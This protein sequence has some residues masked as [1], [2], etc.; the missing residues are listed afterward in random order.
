MGQAEHRHTKEQLQIISEFKDA[1]GIEADEI[2]FY[3]DAPEPD[4][5]FEALSLLSLKLGEG[6]R[7]VS[8]GQLRVDS[9]MASCDCTVILDDG[10]TRTFFGCCIIGEKTLDGTLVEDARKA[11]D[12]ASARALRKGL[13]GVGFDPLKA[14][15]ARQRGE[16]VT[17]E[18]EVSQRVK[19]RRA[20]HA[21]RD[22]LGLDDRTYRDYLALATKGKRTTLDM[23]EEDMG[24]AAVFFR[25]IRAARD[26]RS[27]NA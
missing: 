11:L 6:I 16:A 18:E 8:V 1:Y 9:L 21:L 3:G 26:Y 12:F 4:F 5:T 15:R 7:D 14:H 2:F 25:G 19:D 24:R 20:I 22:E 10:R 27:K 13:R 23:S 17:L